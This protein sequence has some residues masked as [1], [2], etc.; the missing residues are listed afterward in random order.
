MACAYLGITNARI[1][2][3]DL[4]YSSFVLAH[5]LGDQAD[6]RDLGTQDTP[7]LCPLALLDQPDGLDWL[8]GWF[9]RLFARWNFELDER[10]SEEFAFCLRE[11]RRTGVRTIGGLRALIPGEQGRIRRILRQY[12]TYW[13]HIFDGNAANAPTKPV[14]V[15]ELRGL[16]GLGQRAL[17]PC[18]RTHPAFHH[19]ESR[20]LSHLDL[21]R[22]VLVAAGRRGLG[23]V[24]VRLHPHLAQEE[25]RLRRLY[26]IAN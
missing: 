18:H 17:G 7:P 4:D 22:R 23:R 3:L 19:R 6:Y 9:E 5:L 15:Y 8:F 20:W 25:L 2:W 26:A 21:R 16:A 11:A 1:A 14:T 10:Q 24:A 13:K 12:S